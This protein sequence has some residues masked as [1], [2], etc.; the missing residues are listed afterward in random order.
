MS[1]SKMEIIV[2]LNKAIS[3]AINE[4]SK[5]VA[6]SGDI[7]IDFKCDAPDQ[8]FCLKI[9]KKGNSRYEVTLVTEKQMD[10]ILTESEAPMIDAQKYVRFNKDTNL[11]ISFRIDYDTPL[12]KNYYDN[13][14]KKNEV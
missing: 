9:D 3:N 6:K 8:K 11:E 7:V 12:L 13:E 2:G 1:K 5:D 14:E 10:L 4:M